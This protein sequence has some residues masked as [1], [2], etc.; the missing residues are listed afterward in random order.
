MRERQLHLLN[1]PAFLLALGL[2]LAND[3]FLKQQF[4]N[5]ITGKLSDVAGLFAFALFWGAIFPRFRSHAI[6][7]TAIGFVFWKSP[8][9]QALIDGWNRVAPFAVSRT[10]DWTDLIALPVLP[11]AHLYSVRVRPGQ[12]RRPLIYVVAAVSLFA[13][14]ATSSRKDTTTFDQTYFFSVKKQDFLQR[15]SR[16]PNEP[17]NQIV[18]SGEFFRVKFDDCI[19]DAWI[20]VTEAEGKTK[21]RLF[22]IT[23]RCSDS[24]ETADRHKLTIFFETNFIKP[25]GATEVRPVSKLQTIRE[26]KYAEVPGNENRPV[27]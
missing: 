9:S 15:M 14:V 8:L 19:E 18:R 26:V 21:V 27:P 20:G 16:L 25:L 4:H 11:L 12:I 5:A 24:N 17:S 23:S 13:F 10:V 22:A 2:L 6:V 1:S 7:L 3:F